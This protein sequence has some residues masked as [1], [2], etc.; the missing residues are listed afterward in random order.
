MRMAV[1][2]QTRARAENQPAE[3]PRSLAKTIAAAP[4]ALFLI[5]LMAI[6]SV[7][8][9]IGIPVGWLYIASLMVD[10]SQPTLGP[11]ILILFGIPIT[12]VVFGKLLFMLDRAFERVTGRASETEFRAPWLKSMRAE[13]TNKKRLTVLEG[14]M[15]VSVSLALFCFGAWFFLFAG[16]SLPT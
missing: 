7:I 8:L 15:I 6:G 13:R 10:S 14:V 9:W 3:R 1:A 4:A 5:V 16:S 11:Y 12:M 2:E